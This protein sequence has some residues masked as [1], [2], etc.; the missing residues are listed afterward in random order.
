MNRKELVKNYVHI[1]NRESKY[2]NTEIDLINYL[3]K[4]NCN[5]K[6]LKSYHYFPTVYDIVNTYKLDIIHS[7][8][9]E[10]NTSYFELKETLYKY[11]H[12]NLKLIIENYENN[13]T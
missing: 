11:I 2:K 12:K 8:L 10:S 1:Y 9:L 7:L 13:R 3:S 4:R 6:Y 5:N